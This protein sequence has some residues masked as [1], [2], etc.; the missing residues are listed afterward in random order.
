MHYRHSS[1]ASVL[2][3]TLALSACRSDDDP[4]AESGDGDGDGD[5]GGEPCDPADDPVDE[6][7]C[8]TL[9]SDYMP[10]DSDSDTYPAC[11]S[12]GGVYELVDA[13]PGTIARIEAYDEIAALL[14]ENGAPTREDFTDARAAYELEEGLG[15]RVDRREDLHYPE[16]PM[17]EW[18]PGLDPDK[19][20]SNDDLASTYSDRCVGPAKMRPIINEAF[21]AGMSGEGDLNVHAARIEAALTWFFYLS[22]YKEA[23]TCTHTPKD[24][25][26]SWAYYAG[27]AQADGALI[28]FAELVNRYSPTTHQRIFD[29]VLAVRCFRDLYSIDDYPTYADLPADGQQLFDAAWEQLDDALARGFA[30][31]LR[32][33]LLAHDD[34]QCSEATAANWAFVQIV[35]EALDREVRERDAAVADELLAIYELETPTTDD[36]EQ[37]ADLLDQVIPCS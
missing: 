31:S 32:Q 20:C 13:P 19:Q 22:V 17:E 8:M 29:G 3:I 23:Y 9:P 21:I 16:I 5:V 37:A 12:D 4:M 10:S 26:S 18:D 28:G 34:E 27:G 1:L 33:H 25:D 2:F 14:W 36:L 11:I 30:V 7:T 6:A 35:G 24:C 15:S